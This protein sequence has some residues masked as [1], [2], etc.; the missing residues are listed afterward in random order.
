M[1]LH[2]DDIP[3]GI[4]FTDE[5]NL[6]HENI[7]TTLNNELIPILRQLADEEPNADW[8]TYLN[9][10]L[11]FRDEHEKSHNLDVANKDYW[12][13][14]AHYLEKVNA[15]LRMRNGELSRQQVSNGSKSQGRRAVS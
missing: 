7:M 9:I 5:P 8:L 1:Y 6:H 13:S 15:D 11:N 10:F 3:E 12:K 2:E 14:Y 4:H